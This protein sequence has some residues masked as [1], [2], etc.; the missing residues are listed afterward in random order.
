MNIQFRVYPPNKKDTIIIPPKFKG[1]QVHNKLLA[2]IGLN[3]V[4]LAAYQLNTLIYKRFKDFCLIFANLL[5]RH[6]DIQN[7]WKNGNK[8]CIQKLKKKENLFKTVLK[9]SNGHGPIKCLKRYKF[10]QPGAKLCK[11]VQSC[12]KR[13]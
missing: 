2:Y 5:V 12:A 13:R 11:A 4:Y 3:W 7:F 6:T 10:K 8:M 1:G 9:N